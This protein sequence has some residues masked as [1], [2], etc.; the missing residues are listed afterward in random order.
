M[1]VPNLSPR[2]ASE[3][4]TLHRNEQ[5][6]I[7]TTSLIAQ[8]QEHSWKTAELKHNKGVKSKP[9]SYDPLAL[10]FREMAGTHTFSEIVLERLDCPWNVNQPCRYILGAHVDRQWLPGLLGFYRASF[11]LAV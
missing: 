7:A 3:Q 4:K 2:D 8:G 9:R 10:F 11:G 1:I 5:T 6:G